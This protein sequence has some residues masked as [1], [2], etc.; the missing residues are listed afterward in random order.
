MDGREITR[1]LELRDDDREKWFDGADREKLLDGADREKLLE[2]EGRETLRDG[3]DREK[4]RL[5]RAAD[6]REIERPDDRDILDELLLELPRLRPNTSADAN[7]S[8][9]STQIAHT[10]FNL[11]SFMICPFRFPVRIG[12]GV[13]RG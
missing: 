10:H 6:E 5:L 7:E 13:I 8:V 2:D 3:A 12:D 4:L 11:C 9:T 1:G